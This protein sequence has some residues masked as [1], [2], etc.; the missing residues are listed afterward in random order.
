V[1]GSARPPRGGPLSVRLQAL[2]AHPELRRFL[3]FLLVG[4]INTLVGYAIFAILLLI[5]AGDVGAAIG[6]TI[7]GALFNFK[8]IGKLVFA[9]SGNRMLPRFM[10]VYAIQ[11]AA[12]IT[13]L[14]AFASLGIVP[15]I[16][17]AFILPLLAVASFIL[18]RHWV[19]QP[20]EGQTSLEVRD[21]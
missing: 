5:G 9:S 15:L 18:M 4:V 6:A 8:S 11:C 17:E 10:A 21:S 13:L 14:K 20:G 7:L 16:S 1:N 2:R 19:F 3:I 12:N